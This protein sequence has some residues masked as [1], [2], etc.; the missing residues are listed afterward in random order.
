MLNQ[1]LEN[2]RVQ[3][4]SNLLAVAL[5]HHETGFPEYGEV[6]RYRRPA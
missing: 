2:R 1:V 4:V 6:S 3:L 5:G